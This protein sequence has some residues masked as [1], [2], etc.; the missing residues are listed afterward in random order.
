MIETIY[1]EAAV[2]QH[3]RAQEVIA[4][5]PQANVIACEH[6]GEIFNR[7]RQSFV[8]Q[9]QRPALILAQKT[10][11]R[12]LPIP[13]GYGID[14]AAGYYFSHMLNCLYDC[15]Y[16]FLQGMF[17]SAHYV[18][19]VNYEDFLADIA[20]TA[21]GTDAPCWFFSGYDCDSLALEPLTGFAEK[22]VP[23]LSTIPNAWL[24][25]RTKSTQ[26]R[27]LLQLEPCARTVCA[28]SLN[29]QAVIDRHEARTPTLEARL[30]AIRRLQDHGWPVA[31]RFD[32]MLL[33]PDCRRHYAD[34]FARTFAA[35][36][37]NRLHSITYGSFRLPVA[38]HKRM[39]AMYPDE[40]LFA[41]VSDDGNGQAGYTA[42]AESAL[43][44]WCRAEISRYAVDVPIYRQAA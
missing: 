39:Q 26:I 30:T 42:D 16:C 14:G 20:E 25:L 9:K 1:C 36:D 12:V 4:R 3:P 33:I 18:L 15:R 37:V 21:G 8:L 44:E 28:F 29:P 11:R 27:R 6:Y 22:F 17:R 43:L 23:A 31:L 38:Y 40:I 32:P 34:F 24:E 7:R 5:Y 2:A 41:G 19:F 13:A 10:G 35:L